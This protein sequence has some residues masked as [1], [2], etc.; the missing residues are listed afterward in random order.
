MRTSACLFFHALGFERPWV[1]FGV[2]AM[3]FLLN[4]HH[5]GRECGFSMIWHEIRL[6]EMWKI[7]AMHG[8]EPGHIIYQSDEKG[9]YI[10]T[11]II[12]IY[13]C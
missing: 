6:T 9:V 1:E 2:I 7:G 3:V 11:V 13:H 4:S 8:I 5:N 12:W 10:R